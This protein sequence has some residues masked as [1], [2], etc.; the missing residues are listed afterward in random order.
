M[1]DN[2]LW[3]SMSTGL[4]FNNLHQKKTKERRKTKVRFSD[5]IEIFTYE[6]EFKILTFHER[7]LKKSFN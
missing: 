2:Y 6:A 7:S 5:K 3:L 4:D 1:N